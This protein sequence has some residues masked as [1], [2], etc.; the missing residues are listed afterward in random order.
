LGK[1]VVQFQHWGLVVVQY[2]YGLLR[3]VVVV[4]FRFRELVEGQAFLRELVVQALLQEV[5]LHQDRCVLPR[6][7]KE[8]CV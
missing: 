6:M 1:L 8:Q 3:G 2:Y 7:A 5:E 4:Q